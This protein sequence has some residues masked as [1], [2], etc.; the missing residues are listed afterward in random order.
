MEA[1]AAHLREWPLDLRVW[2]YQN[3]QRADLQTPKG[4]VALKAGVRPF[5][6]REREPMRWD[7]WTMQADG[8]TGGRDVVEPSGWLH[9][10]WMGRYYGF[11]KAAA[12]GGVTEEIARLPKGVS[13]ARDYTGP[14]RP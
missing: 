11:I 10:Y 5:S 1:S 6:P 8:G 12:N 2:S 7:G 14:A 9:A 3:S 13:G 4:Y